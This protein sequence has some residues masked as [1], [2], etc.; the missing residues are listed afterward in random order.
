[1]LC[2]S[3]YK[4]QFTHLQNLIHITTED[5]I[6]FERLKKEITSQFLKQHTPSHPDISLWKGQDIVLFQED[7]KLRVKGSLSEKS[8][9]SYFKNE[10]KKLPRIDILNLLSQYCG[11]SSWAAFKAKKNEVVETKA[12]KKKY[13]F[14]SILSSLV[15]IAILLLYI[16]Y[17]RTHTYHFCF[18]DA[19]RNQSI[20]NMPITVT[21]IND[22]QSPYHLKSDA[23]G[24]F[25]WS[26]SDD[27]IKFI[28]SSPYHKPDTIHRFYKNPIQENVLL[29]TDDY[30]LMIHYYANHKIKDW[31]TRKQELK[32]LIADKAVIFQVLPYDIGIELF[33]KEEFIKLLTTP[34]SQLKNIE[35]VET[36]KADQKIVKLKFKVKS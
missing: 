6:A 5:K 29:H 27:Y 12:L 32:Q 7:L 9:Y 3:F 24:C 10:P 26:S 1:M 17:P 20:K 2:K 8:F 4:L 22:H 18:T 14:I 25:S 11:I 13:Q 21:I 36:I 16:F 31:K 35:I 23:Q 30:A 34:T 15:F 33:S 19:D 28:A